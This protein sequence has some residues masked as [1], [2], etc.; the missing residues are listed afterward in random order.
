[1]AEQRVRASGPAAMA[2]WAFPAACLYL[3]VNTDRTVNTYDEGI[4]L[5]GAARVL[6]GWVPHRDFYANYGPG[7]FTSLAVLF[8]LF[9][10]SVLVERGWDIAVRACIVSLVLLLAGRMAPRRVALQAAGACCT[11]LGLLGFAC[12]PVFPALAAAL[13]GQAF[14]M[15]ARNARGRAPVLLGAGACMG[16]AALFRYDVGVAGLACALASVAAA[17]L[18]GA[19]GI[20]HRPSALPAAWA[21]LVAGF[22]AITVPLVAAY[23]AFGVLPGFVFDIFTYPVHFYARM[24]ALPFPTLGS[25]AAAPAGLVV[26]FPVLVGIAAAL[27]LAEGWRDARRLPP[28]PKR[29]AAAA[30]LAD[31]LSFCLLGLAFFLKGCVRV[32]PIHMA[33]ALVVCLVLLAALA[34]RGHRRG[35]LARAF[36]AA[37]MVLA[38]GYTFLALGA[39]T[40]RAAQNLAWAVQ[41][42]TW[43]ASPWPPPPDGTCNPP[44]DLRR[45][46]CFRVPADMAETVRYL[47]QR[48]L[49]ADPVF[50]GLRRHDMIVTND[51]LLYFA[52][53]RPPA[54][55]WYH[56]DPGLQTSL[57]IQQEMVAELRRARP[58]Y[59]VIEI[60]PDGLPEP[61]GSSV[62]SGVT[63]LDDDLRRSYEP[64]ARFGIYSIKAAD[65]NPP[66]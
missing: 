36:A 38:G 18:L 61:N 33:M 48:T 12:Y 23:A 2:A 64:V 46:R 24:R 54:T 1:M 22:G 52:L 31:L 43:A 4:I 49:P 6:A 42:A 58:P 51:V 27:G 29:Q 21:M 15:A 30:R 32:S 8:K 3:I 25:F 5:T 41:P 20:G 9:G 13:A 35:L 47:R 44:P 59:V 28:G 53:D 57:P 50:V 11:W 10:A 63:L 17:W 16:V 14:L 39:G 40:L 65:P 56:F 26:Y 66:R 55:R 19:D 60:W 7:Q 45:L 37:A 34:T 62:S